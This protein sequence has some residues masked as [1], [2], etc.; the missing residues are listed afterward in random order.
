LTRGDICIESIGIS[1]ENL[2]VEISKWECVLCSM[3]GR[4]MVEIM[5]RKLWQIM[6]D[7]ISQI[8]SLE[9]FMKFDKLIMI[10]WLIYVVLKAKCVDCMLKLFCEW[11]DDDFHVSVAYVVFTLVTLNV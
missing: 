7:E 8:L 4:N 11:C 10:I 1:F 9:N 6:S 5:L 3:I 2:D